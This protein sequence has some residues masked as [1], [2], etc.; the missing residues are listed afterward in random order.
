MQLCSII[1]SWFEVRRTAYPNG[2]E[3]KGRGGRGGGGGQEREKKGERPSP[4][5]VTL[6]FSLGDLCLNNWAMVL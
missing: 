4:G 3:I 2:S 6:I 5:I 1:N